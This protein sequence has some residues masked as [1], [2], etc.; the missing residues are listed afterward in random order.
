MQGT[1]DGVKSVCQHPLGM[2]MG[3]G[4]RLCVTGESPV[5]QRSHKKV[6]VCSAEKVCE[7]RLITSQPALTEVSVTF[8]VQREFLRDRRITSHPALP[9]E[10]SFLCCRESLSVR[11]AGSSVTRH[12]KKNSHLHSAEKVCLLSSALTE[13]S[14]HCVSEARGFT[15]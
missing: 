14:P 10:S 8:M 7:R 5:T 1:S 2:F 9:E 3:Q 15:D 6:H 12:S 4:W 11:G 13:P